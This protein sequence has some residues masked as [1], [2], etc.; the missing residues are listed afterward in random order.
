MAPDPLAPLPKAGDGANS[1]AAEPLEQAHRGAPK[2]SATCPTATAHCCLS[3]C[4][5]MDPLSMCLS[6]I[7]SPQT[8]SWDIGLHQE[9]NLLLILC[10]A[11][12][13]RGKRG[14][15]RRQTIPFAHW[16]VQ[17]TPTAP[18]HVPPAEELVRNS[19]HK[20]PPPNCPYRSAKDRGLLSSCLFTCHPFPWRG[21]AATF[22]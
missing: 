7:P 13:P 2:A 19:M 3:V 11:N 20:L 17:S 4:P 8:S 21:S 14:E 16:L 1:G 5:S 6:L 15:E 10:R 18:H 9:I 12:S 22:L